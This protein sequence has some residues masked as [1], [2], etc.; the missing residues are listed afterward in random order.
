VG[1]GWRD[2]RGP[3][4]LD[5]MTTLADGHRVLVTGGCLSDGPQ[6]TADILD[7]ATMSWS[8][9]ADMESTRCRHGAVLLR[10][11]RVL[12]T[13]ASSRQGLQIDASVEIYNPMT[14][15]W[16]PAAPMHQARIEHAAL[17]LPDGR[18]LVVGGTSDAI[19]GE[20]GALASAEIYDPTIDSW[21]MLPVLH[22]ARRSPAAAVLSDGVY[23]T[24]GSNATG[25]P[26]PKDPN[27]IETGTVQI[28]ATTE[29]LTLSAL[30]TSASDASTTPDASTAPDASTTP[31]AS[32]LPDASAPMP[33]GLESSGG[34]CAT[35]QG[36][37]RMIDHAWLVVLGL[38]IAGVRRR[39]R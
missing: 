9:A 17:L 11:G 7:V 25:V 20:V 27:V 19:N 35:A 24:G 4:Y 32:T 10:D 5:R 28:L 13:G 22:D 29:R 38:A 18:V 34:S 1:D 37:A 39:R 26:S 36:E 14:D 30:G 6:R 21:T 8:R 3:A 23:V 15:N 12:V 31:D 33:H 2:A 16:S